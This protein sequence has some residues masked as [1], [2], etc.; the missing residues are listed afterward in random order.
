MKLSL[1]GPKGRSF[2][3]RLTPVGS[4][5]GRIELSQRLGYRSR[6]TVHGFR[7][8]ASTVLNESGFFH[9][10]HIERQLAHVP[11]DEIRGIYNAAE[12]MPARR[13]MMA[14]WSDY[15]EGLVTLLEL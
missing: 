14:W 2:A 4:F 9:P 5:C 8:L 10:D 15:L 3:H 11:G 6:Q 7:R 12:W 1:V 13:K